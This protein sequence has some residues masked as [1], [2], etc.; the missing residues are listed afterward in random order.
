M[1][2]LYASIPVTPCGVLVGPA[3]DMGYLRHVI[4]LGT[5][6]IFFGMMMT[7]LGHEYY[8]LML[9]QGIVTGVGAGGVFLPSI[10]IVP[11]W[12]GPKHRTAVMGIVAM[13]SSLGGVVFPIMFHYI[14][15]SAGFGWALRAI[16]FI[17]LPTNLFGA[18]VLKPRTLPPTRRSLFDLSMFNERPY[19]FLCAA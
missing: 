15:R 17:T 12:F 18:L 2:R 3:I 16:A 11:Q 1:D 4:M 8:Q 5:F 19:P 9:A 13:G 10:T 14:R 6:L 7:S